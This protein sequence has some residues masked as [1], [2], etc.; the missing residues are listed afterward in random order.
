M[1]PRLQVAGKDCTE[2]RLA[3]LDALA[4]STSLTPEQLQALQRRPAMA[5][6]KCAT[7]ADYMDTLIRLLRDREHLVT[8]DFEVPHR[9]SFAG[10][11]WAKLKKSLW[12]ICRY[13]HDYMAGQ[14]NDINFVLGSAIEFQQR[15]HEDSVRRLEQRI[16]HLESRLGASTGNE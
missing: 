2:T 3:Q 9:N 10:R 4:R 12:K 5:L 6:T 1:T 8:V 14:Q 7:E 15:Q 11:F 16:A 13:Q